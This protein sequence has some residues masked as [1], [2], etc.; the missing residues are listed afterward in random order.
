MKQTFYERQMGGLRGQELNI[1]SVLTE[2]LVG[3]KVKTTKWKV[4]EIHP[5]F[6]TAIRECENGFQEKQCFSVGDLVRIGVI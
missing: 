4:T 1:C 6:V 2:G 3:R 5:H